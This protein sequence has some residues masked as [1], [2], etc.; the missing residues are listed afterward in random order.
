MMDGAGAVA[1]VLLLGGTSEI[2]QEIVRSMRSPKLRTVVLA[3]RD[4]EAA[5]GFV[6]ELEG[7]EVKVLVEPFDAAQ[8]AGHGD[9]VRRIVAA[10]GD[11]D[12]AVLAAGQLGPPDVA[13]RP[14][15]AAN[16]MSANMAG[17]TSV[18]LEVAQL[19]RR[20]GHGT[21][22]VLSSVA[23]ERVRRANFVYGASKAGLDALAQGLSA[24][25]EGTGVRVIV[26]RPG[27]VHT[28]MTAGMRP[29]PLSTTAPA[30]AAAVRRSLGGQAVVIWTPWALRPLFSVLRHLPTK[31]FRRLPM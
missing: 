24:W 29:A 7:S 31:V 19:M 21:I 14:V 16:L 20:Q 11:I 23:G 25:L 22:V 27:F 10:V 26:V 4:P 9:L 12:L 30:V 28:R 13:E 18:L 5:T 3:C 6:A 17:P 2:G 8:P 15:D 1:S